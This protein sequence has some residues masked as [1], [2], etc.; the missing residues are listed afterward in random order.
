MLLYFSFKK[1]Y[2]TG[3]GQGA[4]LTSHQGLLDQVPG[5]DLIQ[6]QNRGLHQDPRSRNWLSTGLIL[7]F[8]IYIKSYN[9]FV[10]RISF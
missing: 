4:D 6:D 1:Q 3:L 10:S 8:K 2:Y 9:K 5:Q 7:M